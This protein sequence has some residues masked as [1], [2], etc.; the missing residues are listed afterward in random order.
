[1]LESLLI[2]AL[3]ALNG[4]FAMSEIAVVSSRKPRL[5]Q[6]AENGDRNA[7]VALELAENP[8]RFLS[9][10]QIGITLVGVLAGAYGG[11]ALAEDLAPWVA[12][13]PILAPYSSGIAFAGVVIIITYLS[14][15]I[16]ELVPKH[17]ALRRPEPVALMVARP[18]RVVS[19]VAAPLVALLSGSTEIVLKL[20]GQHA[21]GEASIT[22]EEISFLLAEGAQAGVFEEVEQEIIER[23]FRFGDRSVASMMTPRTEIECLR[24]DEL[25]DRLREAVAEHPHTRFVVCRTNLDD[26]AG[27]VHVKDMLAQHLKEGRIELEGLL[28][29]PPFVPENMSALKVLEQ[30]KRTGEHLAIVVDEYGGVSGL[31][32]LDDILEAIVGDIPWSGEQAQPD[33]VRRDDGSWLIEGMMPIDEFMDLFDLRTLPGEESDRFHTLGGFVVSYLGHI[34]TEADRFDWNGLRFEVIDMDRQ[35][36]DK[37]LVVPR[38]RPAV[39]PSG[40]S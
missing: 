19:I 34:P 11:V 20:T 12:Q 32:T 37:V 28:R 21:S 40:D 13:V 39:D 16:G 3:I 25:P 15:V 9:T 26:T 14:L 23:V 38:A 24:I 33:A 10:V 1:M 27:I 2:L 36:V 30:F 6:M 18:M 4:A 5:R 17:I 29:Q 31:V 35:R 7:A 22:E 8:S